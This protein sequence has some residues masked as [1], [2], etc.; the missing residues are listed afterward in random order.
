MN[1]ELDVRGSSQIATDEE[2]WTQEVGE[3]SKYYSHYYQHIGAMLM[4]KSIG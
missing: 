4:S 1:T 2:C 3:L